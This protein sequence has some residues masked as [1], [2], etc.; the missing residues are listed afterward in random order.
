MRGPLGYALGVPWKIKFPHLLTP[1]QLLLVCESP[2]A[3][4]CEAQIQSDNQLFLLNEI[5]FPG[6]YLHPVDFPSQKLEH[7]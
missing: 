7:S 4:S 1:F 5:I 6:S 2:T 3:S